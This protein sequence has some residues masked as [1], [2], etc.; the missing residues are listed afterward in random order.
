MPTRHE[1]TNKQWNKI[2]KY[3]PL[4]SKTG[5]PRADDRK[6]LNG[7]IYVLRTGCQWYFMP[8]KYGSYKTCH[9]RLKQWQEKGYWE[10]IFHHLLGELDLAG[11][12]DLT[13]TYLDATKRLSKKGE[14]WL[15]RLCG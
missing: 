9:R 8:E 10:N 1:L 15:V 14:P 13:V 6:T 2:K 4:H 7:I 11:K 3:I 12:L 5:R